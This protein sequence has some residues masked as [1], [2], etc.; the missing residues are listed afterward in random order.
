MDR[1]TEKNINTLHPKAQA[2]ARAHVKAIE[3]SGV[4]PPGH[5]VRI[6]SGHRSYAEQDALFAQGRSKPGAKVTNARGGQSWHNFGVAWEI[7]IF[8]QRG[9]YLGSSSLYREL[10]EVGEEI[11]LEWGGR[12]R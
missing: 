11:G 4:L 9:N 5:T 1:R 8:H 12:W 2:W 3:E 7:G 10:G 6:I